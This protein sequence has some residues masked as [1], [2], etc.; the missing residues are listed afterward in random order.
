MGPRLDSAIGLPDGRRL[1]YC[2]W[3]SAEGPPVMFING[4]PGSRIWIPDAQATEAAGVRLVSFDRPGIGGSDPKACR[5]LADIA[6]DVEALARHLH[7]S[8]FPVVGYS[9]GGVYAAACGALVADRV[10][11]V[12][13]VA[14]RFLAEYNHE[15]RPESVAGFGEDERA[16]YDLAQRDPAA[17][18]E[19]CAE[20]DAEWVDQ[21]REHPESIWEGP[22]EERAPEG[23]RWFWRDRRRTGEFYADTREALRQGIDGYKWES[24]DIFLPWGF[25]LSDI[26]VPVTLWWGLQDARYSEERR[27]LERWV[28]ERIPVCRTVAW[29]DSGH[30]G[31]A[32]HWREVLEAVTRS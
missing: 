16:V 14:T 27:P 4:S 30:M 9:T 24:L 17:A 20:Q 21:M 32:K 13:I 1:A 28:Q 31:I 11:Q 10:T 5:T 25:R 2:E 22:A 7:L 26:G 18:G 15:E 19:L 3:G 12:S 8:H 6:G 29:P 23:D